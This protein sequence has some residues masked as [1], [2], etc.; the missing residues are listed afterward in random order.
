MKLPWI[1]GSDQLRDIQVTVFWK[2]FI[3][4]S[5]AY[6]DGD[7]RV[8]ERERVSPVSR[9]TAV[10]IIKLDILVKGCGKLAARTCKVKYY[11][12]LSGTW[13]PNSRQL[14]L[15]QPIVSVRYGA[16]VLL[17]HVGLVTTAI[18]GQR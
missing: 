7:C 10:V 1:P 2:G 6:D 5:Q 18:M 3:V 8:A 11:S 13:L 12:V 15:S 9:V 4:Q 17:V 14:P 16:V